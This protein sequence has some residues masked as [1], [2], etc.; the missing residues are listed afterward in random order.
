MKFYYKEWDKPG[1]EFPKGTILLDEADLDVLKHQP[2]YP[3]F[4]CWEV[5]A[6]NKVKENKEGYFDFNKNLLD[7][8]AGLGE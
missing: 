2:M 8:G 7:I 5:W 1:V 3:E 6:I 4:L